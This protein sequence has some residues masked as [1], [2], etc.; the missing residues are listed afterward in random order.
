MHPDHYLEFRYEDFIKQP[1]QILLRIASFLEI[2]AENISLDFFESDMA[3]KI[4]SDSTHPL[5]NKQFAKDNKEKWRTRM[6]GKDRFF[7]DYIAG[8][9]LK[10][11]GYE[12]QQRRLRFFEY[13]FFQIRI[14]F[15][16]TR[17]V[18]S[19]NYW[20]LFVKAALPVMLYFTNR[21]RIELSGIIK[22]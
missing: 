10:D 11:C 14:L 13:I 15:Y 18:F 21:L 2:P 22:Y 8:K 4:A 1:H 9:V 5:L 12:V 6:T 7:F 16:E 3:V 17:V 20:G 19:R